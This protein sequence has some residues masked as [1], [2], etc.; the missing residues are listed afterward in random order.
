MVMRASGDQNLLVMTLYIIGIAYTFNRMIESID[1]QIKVKLDKGKIDEDLK[2]QNLAG[3]IAISFTIKDKYADTDPKELAMKIENK[4]QS[5]TVYVDWD[6][7]AVIGHDKRSRRMI[8]KSPDPS[9]DLAVAQITS[10]IGPNTSLSETISAEDVFKRDKDTGVYT[11]STPI[12]N[13]PGM[14]KHPVKA[15]R[16][17]YKDFMGR[18]KKFDFQFR[19]SMRVVDTAVSASANPGD[20]RLCIVTCPFTIEKLHWSYAMPW[21][22]KR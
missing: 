19:L 6:N 22:K 5:T 1:D 2:A 7:C 17:G 18:K 21:N 14:E 3:Q 15:V 13:I 11:A 12:V 4:S 9:R 20:S 16:Q 10:V 8:R